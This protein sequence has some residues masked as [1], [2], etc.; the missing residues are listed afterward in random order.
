[1]DPWST[2]R[3]WRSRSRGEDVEVRLGELKE[4]DEDDSQ[5]NDTT[6]HPSFSTYSVLLRATTTPLHSSP[7]FHYFVFY[8]VIWGCSL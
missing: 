2:G 5:R 7:C 6:H 1:M 4:D 3:G 8:P